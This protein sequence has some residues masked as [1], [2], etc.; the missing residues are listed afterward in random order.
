MLSFLL[1]DVVESTALWERAPVPMDGA[2]ARHDALIMEA[3]DS[4]GGLLLKHKGE[5]DST[6]SVFASASAAAAAA[7]DAQ[8]AITAEPWDEA[9]PIAVRM[10]IHTG[11]AF[12]RGHD[13]YGQTVNRAA[14][15]RAL[16]HGG[17]VLLSAASAALVESN[18]PDG[19]ELQFLR[20]EL[21]RGTDRLEAIHELVD[22]LRPQPPVTGRVETPAAP[23][24]LPA[25][26]ASALPRVFVGRGD[27]TD[28]VHEAR[29]RAARG[30]VETVLLGGEPGA[31]KSSVAAAVARVAHAQDWTVLFG[32]CDEHVTTP[33]EPF[34]D[35][36]AQYVACAPTPVLAAHV[37]K[38]GGEI[39][40]LTSNLATRMGA[41]P[42]TEADDP[43]TSRRLLFEAVADLVQ[44][45]AADR[46]LLFVLD[47]MQWADRNSLLLVNRLAVGRDAE[48]LVMLATYRSSEANHS[49]FATVIA[50]LRAL[51]SVTDIEVGGLGHRALVDLLEAGASQA[52]GDD[53]DAVAAYLLDE[54]DGNPLFAVELVRHLVETG[55][56]AP[57]AE[58]H[59]RPQTD[60]A[61]VDVPRSVRAVLSTRVGRLGADAQ[62]VLAVASVAGREFDSSILAT[63]LEL[64]ELTVLD[65]IEAAV[66]ASLVRELSVGHFQFAHALVQHALYD[67][68]SATRRSLHHRQLAIALEANTALHTPAAVL[69]THWVEAGRGDRA[70]VAEWARRAGDD[71]TTALSPDEAMRWYNTA[72]EALDASDPARVDVLIA[73]GTAHRWS[74][75]DE[76][77]RTLL[78]AAALAERLGD[79]DALVRAAI[80]NN[81]GGAGQAGSVDTERVA[82][83]EHALAVVGPGD[84]PERARLLATLAIELSQGGEWERRLALADEA[85]ACARRLGDE[86]TLLRVLLHTTEATR[87]P[88]TLDR[89]LVDTDEMLDLAMRLGDPVLLGIA[90]LRDVRVKIEAAAFDEV[91][92]AM[93]VLDDVA[94]L[95][96]YLRLSRPSVQAV[97]AHVRGDFAQ[98]LAFAQE[99]LV[100]GGSEADAR[101]VYGATTGQVLWDMGSLDSMVP[102]LEQTS[103]AH[104]GVTGFRGLLG[105]GYI[106][107][108][109]ID[110]ARKILRHEVETDFGEHPFN[111]LWLITISEFASMCIALNEVDAALPL[112][113]ILEPWRGRAASSVVSINGLVTE[114]LAGLA[115]VTG[116]LD[117]AERDAD[118]ALAQAVRVGA[119]VSATRTR[120]LLARLF[121]R[122]GERESALAA[123]QAVEA[124]AREMGMAAVQGSAADLVSTL[125]AEPSPS[126]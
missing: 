58:G 13:Y 44:R 47:D 53:G 84:S 36:I 72:L 87:L 91:G 27:L 29:A 80:A 28:V 102:A 40:R 14:R 57:D 64:D 9:T 86:V 99:A 93:A 60:L 15:V 125:G 90:A 3:V 98:A 115:F 111:P 105:C 6:F 8:R 78:D 21:L 97:L 25:A 112:Y 92:E 113:R 69:A 103:A 104:P 37:A 81:R 114:A 43:E 100:V 59:W 94:H 2:L 120:L 46:P 12:Q 49:E 45:A 96:Q 95:D 63:V 61:T 89:R 4:R 35:A 18:L 5:G 39:G 23:P 17:Q 121:A 106:A 70:R 33:Y 10:G 85:V 123:A 117:R 20:S 1:T 56:L 66:R 42:L 48:R 88:P 118:D 77:R 119:R 122:R 68:L 38:H 11:E 76:F 74:D 30:S 31:G 65:H 83:L 82:V 126:P 52:L 79:D 108:G 51:P 41:L 50:Q 26:L 62:R 116:D 73:I 54:T 22:R 55:V 101:A 67:E 7:I 34:R 19:T 110:E 71:A 109:R 16:A 32:S 124:D 75:A 24:S 107:A